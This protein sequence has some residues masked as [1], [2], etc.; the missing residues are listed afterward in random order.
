MKYPDRIEYTTF[1]FLLLDEFLTTQANVSKSGRP[2]TYRDAS[3]IVFNAVMTLKG[4]TA[5]RGQQD[6]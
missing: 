2:E 3:L 5:M 4:I 1:L 6:Y